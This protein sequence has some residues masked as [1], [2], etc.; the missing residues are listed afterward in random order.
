M[1][2]ADWYERVRGPRGRRKTPPA[3]PQQVFRQPR[4]EGLED[5]ISPAGHT[6]ATALRPDFTGAGAAHVADFIASVDQVDLYRVHLGLG[7][8]ITA[9]V[10]APTGSEGASTLRVFDSGGAQR[11]LNNEAVEHPLLSFLARAAGDYYVG[12]SAIGNDRYDPRVANSGGGRY[13]TG[14]YTL[15]LRLTSPAPR[16][17]SRRGTRR[18]MARRCRGRSS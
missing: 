10:G 18:P 17:G 15:D 2:I 16:S 13:S 14:L 11:A 8:R 3:A 5:R 7:E 6:L 1:K 12:V 9:S 4:L